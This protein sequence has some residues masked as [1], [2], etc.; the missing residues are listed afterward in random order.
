MLFDPSTLLTPEAVALEVEAPNRDSAIRAATGLLDPHPAILDAEG[1]T[2]A[3]LAREWLHST[4]LPCG[5]AF[6]HARKSL[7]QDV[8]LSAIRMREAIPFDGIPVRL[9]FVIGTP[10]DRTADH[11]ALLAWLA[12]KMS[13]AT[14]R[15]QLLAARTPQEFCICL[16]GASIPSEAA[17]HE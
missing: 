16:S 15:E 1:F 13:D 10:P 6:P 8:V 7:V 11:L 14:I 9:V 3:V 4:A 2:Q 12:K 17:S 5:V